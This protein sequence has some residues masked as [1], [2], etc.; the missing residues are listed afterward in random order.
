LATRLA[1]L[2]VLAFALAACGGSGKQA[3]VRST[4]P[5]PGKI[6]RAWTT[7]IA[8]GHDEQAAGLFA[9]GAIV[10]EGDNWRVIYT[11]RDAL[12]FNANLPCGGTLVAIS[13]RGERA[14]ATFSLKN[15]P[16]HRCDA[17]R[18]TI[19]AA[20]FKVHHGKITLWR[21]LVQPLPDIH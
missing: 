8:T 12:E 13:V 3:A 10:A 11:E 1:V 16:A 18:G 17:A 15:R 20:L 21:Q 14:L 5:A 9:L 2:V 4:P 19:A 7:A 6:V